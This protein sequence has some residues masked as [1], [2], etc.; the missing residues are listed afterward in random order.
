MEELFRE[1]S[2]GW[3]AAHVE[4]G[5]AALRGT[6]V[7]P[8]DWGLFMYP[9]VMNCAFDSLGVWNQPS[10]SPASCTRP[11]CTIKIL[12]WPE[13]WQQEL[14]HL[15]FFFYPFFLKEKEQRSSSLFSPLLPQPGAR[16]EAVSDLHL[17]KPRGATHLI[18]ELQ[19]FFPDNRILCIVTYFFLKTAFLSPAPISLLAFLLVWTCAAIRY[20]SCKCSDRYRL[21]LFHH[22]SNSNLPRHSEKLRGYAIKAAESNLS[23]M[24]GCAALRHAWLNQTERGQQRD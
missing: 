19:F 10:Q 4:G 6:V 5:P 14:T 15:T 21:P 12:F 16:R 9:V 8:A 18:H 7:F 17:I 2:V 11:D 23:L 13:T 20:D 22:G 24:R 3:K 1:T